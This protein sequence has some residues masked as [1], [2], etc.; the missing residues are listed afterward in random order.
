MQFNLNQIARRILPTSV[1]PRIRLTIARLR[2]PIMER[3]L[4]KQRPELYQ[5]LTNANLPESL[6]ETIMLALASDDYRQLP[7]WSERPEFVT[8]DLLMITPQ[9]SPDLL[10]DVIVLRSQLPDLH[11]TLLMGPMWWGQ[12]NVTAKHFDEI[13]NYGNDGAV[14]LINYLH[15]ISARSTII[16]GGRT[17]LDAIAAIFSPGRLIFRAE[18]WMCAIPGYDPDSESAIIE[19]YLASTTDGMYH[20]WGAEA[21]TALR[22]IMPIPGEIRDIPPACVEEL[23]PKEFLPKLSTTDGEPH[24]V[25]P[26]DMI[27]IDGLPEHLDNWRKMTD[28]GIHIHYHPPRPGWAKTIRAQPYVQLQ[29]ESSYF[30]I[31]ET[32]D[33][34]QALNFFTRYDWAYL[35][36]SAPRCNVNPGFEDVAPNLIYT[37]VQ[38]EL[39]MII[40]QNRGLNSITNMVE[41]FDT[42]VALQTSELATVRPRLE[43]ALGKTMAKNLKDRREHFTFDRTGL[44]SLVFPHSLQ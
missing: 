15:G 26:A 28:Q 41:E 9:F 17:Y 12:E 37:F 11:S 24:V 30:H 29:L 33:F 31:E 44:T 16:R 18:E 32:L 7:I 39:P 20:Y 25:F 40:A 27:L 19:K 8:T 23:G 3:W 4:K 38:S 35:H 10:K 34:E 1:R 22:K 14:K 21:A 13:I 42:G 2:R 43:K 6:Y 5:R 36:M